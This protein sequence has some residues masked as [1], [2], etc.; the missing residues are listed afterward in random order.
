M[1]IYNF[2]TPPALST[3][4]VLALNISPTTATG[5][6]S[7]FFGHLAYSQR[8][9][10]NNFSADAQISTL[11]VEVVS[12]F[13]IFCELVQQDIPLLDPLLG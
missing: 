5:T 4:I 12:Y 3:T 13:F 9:K 11:A 10:Q 8:S 6:Q 1:P 7:L 2:S